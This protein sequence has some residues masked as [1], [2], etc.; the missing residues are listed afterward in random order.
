MDGRE[1]DR[2]TDSALFYLAISDSSKAIL[3]K[4][5]FLSFHKSVSVL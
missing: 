1:I 2:G 4:K 3:G 5:T